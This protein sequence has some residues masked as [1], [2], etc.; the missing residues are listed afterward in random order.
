MASEI[1]LK[2]QLSILPT[3]IGDKNYPMWSRRIT[4]FLKHQEL[5]VTVTTDPGEAPGNLVRKKLSEAAN[6]LLTK[7]SNK[8]YNQIITDDNDNNGF[9]I[10]T[11]I[12]DLYAKQTGLCLSRCLT[13]WHN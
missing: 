7:I 12:K 9:L 11:R 1:S 3:L 2:D 5:Y 6:I 13:Q 4:A 10:W 8:L